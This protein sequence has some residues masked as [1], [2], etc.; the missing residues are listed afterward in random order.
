MTAILILL[1]TNLFVEEWKGPLWVQSTTPENQV[2]LCVCASPGGDTSFE[3]SLGTKRGENRLLGVTCLLSRSPALFSP[4]LHNLCSAIGR[5]AEKAQAILG[6]RLGD[7][8]RLCGYG[9]ERGG[10]G[11]MYGVRFWNL[12]RVT[13]VTSLT[14]RK[15]AH[16][17][18]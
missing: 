12:L 10:V 9:D 15:R 1:I 11:A 8:E 13:S 17:G 7:C 14:A 5:A 18:S 3:R 4:V 2:V 16:F 6:G